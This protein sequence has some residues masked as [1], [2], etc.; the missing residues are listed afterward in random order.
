[1]GREERRPEKTE[2]E[3]GGWNG[4]KIPGGGLT[5]GEAVSTWPWL[6]GVKWDHYSTRSSTDAD[7]GSSANLRSIN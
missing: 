2:N 3:T 5:W 1:M 6:G 7:T 4:G